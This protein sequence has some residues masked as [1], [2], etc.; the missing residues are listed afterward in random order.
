MFPPTNVIQKPY[1]VIIDVYSHIFLAP[2]LIFYTF[3]IYEF[4]PLQLNE[5]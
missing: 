2:L 5:A 1:Q 3:V 4:Q